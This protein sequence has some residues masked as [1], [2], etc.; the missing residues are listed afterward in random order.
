MSEGVASRCIE[1]EPNAGVRW[2]HHC[3]ADQTDPIVTPELC[4]GGGD[5]FSAVIYIR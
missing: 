1:R 3:S 4:A 5:S 2:L